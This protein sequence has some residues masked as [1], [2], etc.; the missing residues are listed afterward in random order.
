MIPKLEYGD[1]YRWI[2][3]IGLLLILQRF[4]DEM[5]HRFWPLHDHRADPSTPGLRPA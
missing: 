3:S 2:V 4:L 5:G 1:L